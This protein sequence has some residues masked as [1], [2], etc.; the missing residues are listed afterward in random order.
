MIRSNKL[1]KT[2]TTPF[3]CNGFSKTDFHCTL[4]QLPAVASQTPIDIEVL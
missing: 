1:K 3:Q 2:W 4:P